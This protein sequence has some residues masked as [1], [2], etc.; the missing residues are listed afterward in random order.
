MLIT[1]QVDIETGPGYKVSTERL[2]HVR[3]ITENNKF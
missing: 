1:Q 3:C 2:M